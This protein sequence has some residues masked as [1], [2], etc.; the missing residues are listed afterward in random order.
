MTGKRIAQLISIALVLIS[1]FA[2][3]AAGEAPADAIRIGVSYPVAQ[4]NDDSFLY[5]GIE[6][7]VDTINAAGGVLGR[8]LQI[9]LRDD[10]GDASV[11][12]QIAQTFADAGV[13]AVIGHWSSNVTYFVEDI[14]EKNEVVMVTPVAVSEQL[15]EYGYDYIFRMIPESLVFA[16]AI[17]DDLQARGIRRIAIFFSDDEYGRDFADA[18]ETALYGTDILVL[19]RVFSLTAGN[20]GVIADRWK[21]FGCEA[22][23]VAEPMPDVAQPIRLIR[24]NMPGMLVY[25]GDNFDRSN[26]SVVLGEHAQGLLMATY[27]DAALDA[28]FVAAF[29][30]AY[31]HQP[32]IHAITGYEAVYLLADAMEAAG[33]TDGKAIAAQLK[34]LTD[35]QTITGVITY[36]ADTNEFT[37]QQLGIVEIR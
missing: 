10:L 13:T 28:A 23:V 5:E 37:G 35:Y 2:M 30:A 6:L 7:A 22:V 1:L 3:P 27:A 17:A 31:G 36:D 21:A 11:A 15:F 26:F 25:G 32:D 16:Q 18:V 14:Y 29:E 24:T 4:H 33:S 9:D 8:P 19:D 34:G 12:M 20:A